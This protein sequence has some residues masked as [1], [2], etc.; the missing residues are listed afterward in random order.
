MQIA[1]CAFNLKKKRKKNAIKI[2]LMKDYFLSLKDTF[3]KS[4]Y[5]F[6]STYCWIYMLDLLDPN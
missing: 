1:Y 3:Y 2:S 6:Y 4:T 5:L